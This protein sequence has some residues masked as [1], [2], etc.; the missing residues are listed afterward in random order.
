MLFN[1]KVSRIA[2]YIVKQAYWQAFGRYWFIWCNEFLEVLDKGGTFVGFFAKN[3]LYR[4]L[5]EFIVH[6][7]L[8]NVLNIY[9]DYAK[10]F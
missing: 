5:N 7:Q 6:I 9:V 8:L 10:H 1:T 2:C 3:V 4:D